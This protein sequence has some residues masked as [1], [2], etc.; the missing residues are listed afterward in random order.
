M[1]VGDGALRLNHH[2]AV[3]VQAQGVEVCDDAF[4]CFCFHPRGIQVFDAQQT[5]S[6]ALL[7][8]RPGDDGGQDVA[9]VQIPRGRRSITADVAQKNRHTLGH[10]R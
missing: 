7:R 3:K 8:P 5:A 1:V 6:L 9:D 2:I 10:R 4:G